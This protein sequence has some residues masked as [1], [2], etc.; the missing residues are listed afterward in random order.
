MPG[1]KWMS[2]AQNAFFLF[3]SFCAHL[4]RNYQK[5][6]NKAKEIFLEKESIGVPNTQNLM[7]ISNP[8]KKLEISEKIYQKRF[9]ISVIKVEKVNF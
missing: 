1:Q 9:L 4:A 6:G 7:Q 8:L 5:N 2:H 3:Q